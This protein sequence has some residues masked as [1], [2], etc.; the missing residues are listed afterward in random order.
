MQ[1]M[2][3]LF[4]FKLSLEFI[5]TCM[6]GLSSL[7]GNVQCDIFGNLSWLNMSIFLSLFD[8]VIE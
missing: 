3:V 1:L 8:F 2:I 6:A 4:H 5:S 7:I